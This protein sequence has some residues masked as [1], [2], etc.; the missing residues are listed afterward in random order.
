MY[1]TTCDTAYFGGI[2][3]RMCTW[4][5]QMAF[6]NLAFSLLSQIAEYLAQMLANGFVKYFPA[7]LRV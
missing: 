3:I 1:P 4:S 7:A 2:E 5:N 6:L